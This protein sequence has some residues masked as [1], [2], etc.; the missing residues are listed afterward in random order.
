MDCQICHLIDINSETSSR[1]LG[2]LTIGFLLPA[3]ADRVAEL[4]VGLVP[5]GHPLLEAPHAARRRGLER[6]RRSQVVPLQL[7]AKK[8]GMF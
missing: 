1:R 4:V 7:A 3:V 5:G 8:Q 6:R 2:H